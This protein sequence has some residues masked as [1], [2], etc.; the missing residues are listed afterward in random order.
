MCF[1]MIGAKSYFLGHLT[2]IK[3]KPV[4]HKIEKKKKEKEE[5]LLLRIRLRILLN[6]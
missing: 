1:Q 5:P 3:E 2:S 4:G 6:Q